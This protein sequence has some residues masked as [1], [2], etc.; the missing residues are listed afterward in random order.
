[1]LNSIK[2]LSR[3]RIVAT[4]GEVGAVAEAVYFDD[5]HGSCATW[6]STQ[7]RGCVAEA[8]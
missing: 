7:G 5:E 1:M 4:D 2:K 6:W 8:C 3:C